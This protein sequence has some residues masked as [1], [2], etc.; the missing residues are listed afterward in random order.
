MVYIHFFLLTLQKDKP[1]K[2]QH[3][4]KLGHT[5]NGLCDCKFKDN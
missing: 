3:P 5:A 2:A 4:S 1:H